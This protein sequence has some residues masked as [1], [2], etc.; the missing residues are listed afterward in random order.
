MSAQASM[1]W[2]YQASFIG[3]PS[4]MFSIKVALKIQAW[5]G[6]GRMEEISRN[7]LRN[8]SKGSIDSHPPLFQLHLEKRFIVVCFKFWWG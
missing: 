4:R 2:W 1:T 5:N 8:E 7:L 3:E 6:E